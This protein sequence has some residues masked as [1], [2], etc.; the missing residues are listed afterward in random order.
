MKFITF[1]ITLTFT[2]TSLSYADDAAVRRAEIAA[3]K[4]EVQS[5]NTQHSQAMK[6]RT[7]EKQVDLRHQID[8]KQAVIN[9][10][11]KQK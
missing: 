11:E 9:A 4:T 2:L 5:L 10:K 1:L 3:L 8:A 6:D 7:F